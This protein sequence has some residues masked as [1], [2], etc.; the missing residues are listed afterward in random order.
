MIP[1]HVTTPIGILVVLWV[2]FRW[3]THIFVLYALWHFLNEQWICAALALVF[4][5]FIELVKAPILFLERL[6]ATTNHG[7][8]GPCSDAYPPARSPHRQTIRAVTWNLRSHWL[9]LVARRGQDLSSMQQYA[10]LDRKLR[11]RKKSTFCK[12]AKRR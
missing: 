2:L 6:V 12:S 11:C 7:F 9:P 3:R 10:A 4:A 1:D 8:N 5:C